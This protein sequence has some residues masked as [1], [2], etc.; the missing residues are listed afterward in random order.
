V[1]AITTIIFIIG[2]ADFVAP[3]LALLKR[4]TKWKLTPDLQRAFE[5]LRAKFADGVHLGHP[6]VSLPYTINTDAS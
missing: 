4:G 2:Y 3:I 5:I 1:S 6:D